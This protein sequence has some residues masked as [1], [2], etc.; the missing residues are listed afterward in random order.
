M[1]LWVCLV[2]LWAGLGRIHGHSLHIRGEPP[3]QNEGDL[4]FTINMPGVKPQ[5]TD[6]YLCT[7]FRVTDLSVE[8]HPFFVTRFKPSQA[9]GER[10][11]HMLLYGCNDPFSVEPGQTWDCRHHTVCKDGSAIMYAWAKNAPSTVLPADVS[12]PV[13]D[14]QFLV[15][16]V[17]YVDSLDDPD[18]T[19]IQLYY[20][21]Q[22]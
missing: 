1:W 2:G 7:A 21:T 6:S 10:A 22:A 14:K 12:F 5:G 19:G 11:H 18:N 9:R 16:Q 15:L 8:T 20:Q 3:A 17:H 13:G 4:S